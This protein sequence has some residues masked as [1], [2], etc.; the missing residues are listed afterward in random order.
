MDSRFQLYNFRVSASQEDLG[1]GPH[2]CLGWQ[3]LAGLTVH[4]A[5]ASLYRELD[6]PLDPNQG[7]PGAHHCLPSKG[8]KHVFTMNS[9]QKKNQPD[10]VGVF[11][12]ADNGGLA[13]G[14]P[15]A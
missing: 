10:L 14:K 15:A 3:W 12:F 11:W 4:P 2:Y 6:E 5:A 7:H 9:V 13:P 8:E 1:I